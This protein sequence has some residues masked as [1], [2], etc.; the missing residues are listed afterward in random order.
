MNAE[1]PYY[2]ISYLDRGCVMRHSY[3]YGTI[4]SIYVYQSIC[5]MSQVEPIR[6][7]FPLSAAS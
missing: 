7:I 5:E 1:N 2:V 4:V 6:A 3:K